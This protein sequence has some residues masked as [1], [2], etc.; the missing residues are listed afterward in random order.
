[1]RTRSAPSRPTSW[2]LRTVTLRWDDLPLVMGIVNVTPNSF[3]DGGRFFDPLPALDHAQELVRQGADLL[4]VGGESTRPY[5]APVDA[6]EELRRVM[7]VLKEL[8]RCGSV[9]VSIDTS[10][11]VVARA[12]IACG[13]EAINDVTGLAG[14]PEMVSVARESG[15]GVCVMHMQGTPAT[16]Q[17]DP[18]YQDVVAEV[19]AYLHQ[20][21][22]R[23]LEA[24]IAASRICLDPG[25][26]FGKTHQHNLELLRHCDRLLDLGCPLLVGPSRKG[27]IAHV[28]GDKQLDRTASTIGVALALAAQGVHVLRVH[29]V[30]P[31]KQALQ[32]FARAGGL[33]HLR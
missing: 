19:A 2:Q 12:A 23:L 26:G 29:D 7:P 21:R 33:D 1:M 3:S 14:D 4:D 9:P 11:A 28:L 30:G 20:R 22:D 31:V 24:G 16:M 25:I 5:A 15:A 17:D 8:C 6:D 18:R 13:A 27:F 10:K 32:L